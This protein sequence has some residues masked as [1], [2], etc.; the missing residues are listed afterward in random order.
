MSARAHH[1]Y[2]IRFI[3]MILLFASAVVLLFARNFQIETHT[4]IWHHH[5]DVLCVIIIVHLNF[6]LLFSYP[7]I[8]DSNDSSG[9]SA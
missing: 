5:C 7:A 2:S 8:S 9:G 6:G 1:N 3:N 4:K